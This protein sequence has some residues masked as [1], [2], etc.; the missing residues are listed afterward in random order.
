VARTVVIGARTVAVIAMLGVALAAGGGPLKA[1]ASQLP[2]SSSAGVVSSTGRGCTVTPGEQ[3]RGSVGLTAPVTTFRP[4]DNSPSSI[5]QLARDLNVPVTSPL[6]AVPASRKVRWI[7]I[8]CR[9]RPDHTPMEVAPSSTGT[10]QVYAPNSCNWSGWQGTDPASLSSEPVIQSYMTV[11]PE[12]PGTGLPSNNT[13]SSFWPGLGSGTS[14]TTDELIQDGIEYDL[15]CQ[16]IGGV[17]YHNNIYYFWFEMYPDESEQEVTN[18]YPNPGDSTEALAYYNPSAKS[19]DFELCDWTQNICGVAGQASPG[20]PNSK[21]EWIAE[22]PDVGYL[23][24]LTNYTTLPFTAAYI[25]TAS[26]S[27]VYSISATHPT[28]IAMYTCNSGTVMSTAGNI[29]T[30]G[31][32]FTATWHSY[33]DNDKC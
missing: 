25:E 2:Q 17:C 19:G 29:A 31:E 26:G 6:V 32:A 5:S 4:N 28:R 30:N 10:C 27:E 9:A 24:Y 14:K 1:S 18:F 3:P 12:A 22:R 15:I 20:P 33:G 8:E 13:Y 11:P 16:Y 7:S 21:A 23:P